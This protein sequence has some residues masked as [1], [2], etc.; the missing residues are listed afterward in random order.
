MKP[1]L[2]IFLALLLLASCSKN[3]IEIEGN[4]K[5]LGSQKVHIVYHGDGGTID[6]VIMAN[7]GRFKVGCM[8]SELTVITVIDFRGTCLAQFAAQNGDNITIKGEISKPEEII[9]EG[10][11]VT[12]KWMAFRKDHSMLYTSAPSVELN[13][14]IE[15]WVKAH[16]K[17]P[18][19]TLLLLFDHS[20]LMNETGTQPLLNIIDPKARPER[21]LA[22]AMWINEY[23]S[24]HTAK[25]VLSL[26]LCGTN[27]E[28]EPLNVKGKATILYF[29][30]NNHEKRSDIIAAIKEKLRSSNAEAI[31]I[32]DVLVD[33]D[34]ARWVTTCRT[35]SAN[36]SHYWVPGGVTD[37]ALRNLRIPTVPFFVAT[38][39]LGHIVYR[40][41]SITKAIGSLP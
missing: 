9:V 16:P 41:T 7:D 18:C 24:R 40:G 13:Q 25:E 3:T 22:A 39:S 11:D 27:G 21:L 33:A 30:S 34:T 23:Y 35:D 5:G 2:T 17:D 26:N 32:A 38:D 19:S 12:E 15:K 20:A 10:N 28:F 36:W 8:S 6:D 37:I 1:I 4:I 29:W 31:T 14:E